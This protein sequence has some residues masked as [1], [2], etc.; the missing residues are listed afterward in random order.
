MYY[1]R[2]YK[3]PLGDILLVSDEKNIIGLWF[4]DHK[5]MDKKLPDNIIENEDNPPLEKGLIW[6]EDYF[7][8]KKPEISSLPISPINATD[9][10][11]EVWE[12]LLEIPYGQ[13]TTYGYIAKEVGKRIGKDK[14]SAQAVGGA[15]GNNP[16][17]I[18]IPCHRV[19]GLNGNLTGYG[20]GINRKIDLLTHEGVDMN[21]LFIPKYSSAP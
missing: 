8:G 15:V 4:N 9:F 5:Y 3:C 20:G 1:S 21:K 2:K 17:S 18:I 14:M 11:K 12:I 7:S 10:R 16:I 19:V 6:L 13:L